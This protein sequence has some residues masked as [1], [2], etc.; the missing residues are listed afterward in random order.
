MD[1]L[2]CRKEEP[3]QVQ[4]DTLPAGHG[5]VIRAVAFD[6]HNSLFASVGDD[7]LVKLWDATAWT[8]IKTVR[9]S[10]KASAVTFSHDS[11]WLL[12]ADKFGIVYVF[13]TVQSDA[14]HKP[15][16]ILAHCCSIITGLVWVCCLNS[17]PCMWWSFELAFLPLHK[18][19]CY[20]Y[21]RYVLNICMYI[22]PPETSTP[23]NIVVAIIADFFESWNLFVKTNANWCD[24]VLFA[25]WKIYRY[26]RP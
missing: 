2:L 8:C 17:A 19:L 1:W 24:P 20:T 5:D 18:L 13:S 7:K 25:R 10:K 23:S 22:S 15:V 4:D 26:F 14:I 16:L 3:V 11:A 12:V 21:S 9:L 6:L